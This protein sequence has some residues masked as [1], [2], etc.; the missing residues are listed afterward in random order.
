NA[1]TAV[2]PP[3]QVR[4]HD[5]CGL[6]LSARP[7]IVPCAVVL[8]TGVNVGVEVYAWYAVRCTYAVRKIIGRPSAITPREPGSTHSGSPMTAVAAHVVSATSSVA[9]AQIPT[10]RPRRI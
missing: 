6:A 9:A 4:R 2:A 10:A 8:P 3:S 7:A 5:T 1:P